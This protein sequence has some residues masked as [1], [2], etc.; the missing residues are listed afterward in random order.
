M[1]SPL[2]AV[3]QPSSKG[4]S[5][6]R[7]GPCPVGHCLE[8]NLWQECPPANQRPHHSPPGTYMSLIL[9][10]TNKTR[11]WEQE[12]RAHGPG[13]CHSRGTDCRAG[14]VGVCHLLWNASP[15]SQ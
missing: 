10:A 6:H 4:R 11:N 13:C 12:K 14:Y 15:P 8:G 5:K 3:T 2:R 7:A 9:M 1:R